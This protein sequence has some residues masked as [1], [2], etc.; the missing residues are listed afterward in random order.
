LAFLK[1]KRKRWPGNGEVEGSIM[2]G[3]G[4]SGRGNQWWLDIRKIELKEKRSWTGKMARQG[5]GWEDSKGGGFKM[6][7]QKKEEKGLDT[8]IGK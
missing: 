6:F 1:K 2:E 3:I 7:F 4:P 5:G 8:R